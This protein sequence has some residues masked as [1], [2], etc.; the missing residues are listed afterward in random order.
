MRSFGWVLLF[1]AAL[2]LSCGAYREQAN[3]ITSGL[4]F[5]A[6]GVRSTTVGRLREVRLLRFGV[7]SLAFIGAAH[8]LFV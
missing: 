8:A 3:M 6:L 7:A 1:F 2:L 4:L 5:L